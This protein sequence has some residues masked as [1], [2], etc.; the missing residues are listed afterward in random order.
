MSGI[1]ASHPSGRC[2]AA[3]GFAILQI[4]RTLQEAHALFILE[5]IL[6]DGGS[7]PIK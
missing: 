3:F 7:H 4:H 5:F 6:M 1:H 2:F